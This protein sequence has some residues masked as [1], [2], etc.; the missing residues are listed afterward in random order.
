MISRLRGTL[1]E[2]TPPTLL[3]DVSGVGY[4]VSAPMSTFHSI[5]ELGEEAQ[6]HIHH[7]I[8][9]DDQ[10]LFGFITRKERHLFRALLKV[11]GVG[12][13]A[14]LAI[15][16]TM[17]TTQIMRCVKDKDV[18]TMQKV[19]GIGAKTAEAL[20]IALQSLRMEATHE[21]GPLPSDQKQSSIEEAATILES[22]GFT[23]I[24]YGPYLNN[25]NS[26]FGARE[27]AL[28]FQ[29]WWNNRTPQE[30]LNIS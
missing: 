4:E 8:K 23:K 26:T 1:L 30:K 25:C 22:M 19:P 2:K 24:E 18:K 3:L 14:G 17:T 7:L 16:S 21:S 28:E 13:K 9:E 5:S 10:M 12:S 27:I 6:L 29:A 11:R 20:L 15:L